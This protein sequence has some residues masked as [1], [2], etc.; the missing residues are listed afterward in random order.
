MSWSRPGADPLESLVG[1][2]GTERA[3]A[4]ATDVT[5][6]GQVEALVERCVERFGGVDIMVNNADVARVLAASTR[7]PRASASARD[8]PHVDLRGRPC[9]RPAS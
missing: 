9:G 3:L 5:D 4:V 1:E 2:L 7:R 6:A 8:Q